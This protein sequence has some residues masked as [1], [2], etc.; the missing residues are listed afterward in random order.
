M[1]QSDSTLVGWLIKLKELGF[2]GLT[3]HWVCKTKPFGEEWVKW[4]GKTKEKFPR[5][6]DMG[7]P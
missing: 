6:F 7:I 2:F 4:A 3:L 5:S 1:G